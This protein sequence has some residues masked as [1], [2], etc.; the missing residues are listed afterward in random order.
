MPRNILKYT[1]IFG[2]KKK[3]KPPNFVIN[4]IGFSFSITI[5]KH[6]KCI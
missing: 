5:K 2:K 3:K 1:C 4:V 6:L